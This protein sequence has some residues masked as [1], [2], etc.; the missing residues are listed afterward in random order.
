MKMETVKQE[1][2]ERAL[3]VALDGT[4]MA[5]HLSAQLPAHVLP[6]GMPITGLTLVD[7]KPGRR[8]LVRYELAARDGQPRPIVYGKLYADRSQLQR[9]NQVLQALHGGLAQA[10]QPSSV[11]APLCVLPAL[12]MLVYQPVGGCFLDEAIARGCG[13][14]AVAAAARWLGA[15]HRQRLELAKAFDLAG[16]LANLADWAAVV[17]QSYPELAAAAQGALGYLRRQAPSLES[18]LNV[19]AQGPIHKDFHYRHVLI[20]RGAR[21]IDF[22][23]VRLGDPNLDLAHFCANLDLLAYRRCGAPQALRRLTQRF[24][25]AYAGATGWSWAAQQRRF[26]YFYVYTCLKLARQLCLG[27]GPSPVPTGDERRRQVAMILQQAAR[28][29]KPDSV[30][31]CLD[32]RK[33][34]V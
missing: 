29:G 20:A 24:L 4:A 21:V 2:W 25:A 33:E 5:A 28:A 9:V 10:G 8:G 26:R 17:A 3:A 15:F 1:S 6:A 22:D 12:S 14:A 18:Q 13:A 11:P 23:E 16:E 34:H 31:V 7:H 27:F 19:P 32:L 30:A